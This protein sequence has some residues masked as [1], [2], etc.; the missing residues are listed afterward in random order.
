MSLDSLLKLI[1]VGVLVGLVALAWVLAFPP[2]GQRRVQ[3][4][5]STEAAW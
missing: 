3:D 4:P 2:F 1:I 5:L